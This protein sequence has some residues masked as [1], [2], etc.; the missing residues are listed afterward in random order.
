MRSV[1]KITMLLLVGSS[2]LTNIGFTAEKEKAI[3]QL[4]RAPKQSGEVTF[5]GAKSTGTYTVKGST[6]TR[7]QE[8]AIKE[9]KESNKT[10]ERELK[11]I[12]AYKKSGQSR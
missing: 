1:T 3:D 4:K 5:D 10:T 9:Y 8:Q 7:T 2:L 11:A 6:S 12:E